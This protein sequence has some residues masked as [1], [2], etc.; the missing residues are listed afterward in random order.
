MTNAIYRKDALMFAIEAVKTHGN[1]ANPAYLEDPCDR[2]RKE[3]PAEEIIATLEKMVEQLDKKKNYKSNK[4][5]K[6]QIANAELADKIAEFIA[7]N[8]AVTCKQVEE[9]FGISNQKAS[10]ILNRNAKFVKVTEAKGKV[11]ATFGLAE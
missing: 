2:F 11:K 5:S 3:I 9:A 1:F 4:P 8:G 6:A 10:A 7:E